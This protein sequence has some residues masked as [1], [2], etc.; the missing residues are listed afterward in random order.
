MIK[1]SLDE[2]SAFDMLSILSLKLKGVKSYKT[3]ETL[4]DEIAHSIGEVLFESIINSNEYE[5]LLRA[6]EEVFQL[7]DD[8]NNGEDF[9]A[10][11]VHKTNMKRYQAKKALQHKF[12]NNN[13]TEVKI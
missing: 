13:L 3:Y 9:S 1:V 10:L 7:V 5:E 12:F 2:A 11:F 6:N 8:M 4:E